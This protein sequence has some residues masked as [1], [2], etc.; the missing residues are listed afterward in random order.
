VRPPV[1][2]GTPTPIL[3]PA[4]WSFWLPYFLV[5]TGL[6][7]AFTIGVYLRGRWTYPLAAVNSVLSVAFA[8]PALWLLL[9]GQLFNPAIIEALDQITGDDWLQPTVIVITLSLGGIV[10]WDA[11]DTFRK[12]RRNAELATARPSAA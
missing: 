4:L 8:V 12:A 11:I 9:T 7:I 10:A 2:D 3:D 5:V 1:V 6:E